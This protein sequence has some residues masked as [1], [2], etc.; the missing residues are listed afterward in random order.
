MDWK[1]WKDKIVE[2][3]MIIEETGKGFYWGNFVVLN[4]NDIAAQTDNQQEEEIVYI[5]SYL[6]I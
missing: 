1:E 5:K 6:E 2:G 3:S 4:W